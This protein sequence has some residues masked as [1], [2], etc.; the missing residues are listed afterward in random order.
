[1]KKAKI[2]LMILIF[3]HLIGCNNYSA[4]TITVL[5]R[6]EG[7]GTR[8]AFEELLSIEE[9][10]VFA[11]ISDSTA[12]M[13]TSV[14]TNKNAIGYISLGA[15]TDTIKPLK[16]DNAEASGEN[17]KNKAYKIS[18]QLSI[19]TKSKI[20]DTAKDFLD[21]VLSRQGQAIVEKNKYISDGNNGEFTPKA[22]SGTVKITGSSS[23][24]PII[25]KLKE[26]YNKINPNAVIEIQQSDSTNGVSST[27]DGICDIG[28]IS[29]QLSKQELSKGISSTVIALDAIAVIVN[30]EN[31]THSISSDDLKNIYSGEITLWSEIK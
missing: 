24:A 26:A 22:L 20:S 28:M 3:A 18:R 21:F 11:E 15:L 31:P 13:I 12:V 30:K 5:S 6:E 4:D 25:E 27:I 17:I 16:V 23:V 2:L 10:T 14:E 1:M 8:T 19:V 9:T 7:S 29:R